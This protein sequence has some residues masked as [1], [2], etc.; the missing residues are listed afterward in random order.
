MSNHQHLR[1]AARRRVRHLLETMPPLSQNSA[2]HDNQTPLSNEMTPHGILKL[3]HV[4]LF[5]AMI[6]SAREARHE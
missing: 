3:S 1:E 5:D 4:S 2:A 6:K